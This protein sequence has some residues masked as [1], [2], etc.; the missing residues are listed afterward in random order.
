MR[1]EHEPYEPPSPIENLRFTI[2]VEDASSG[3]IIE[4]LG[5]LAGVDPA[6]LAYDECVR[7]APNKLILLKHNRR[8]LRRSDRPRD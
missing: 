3:R 2:E 8:L 5:R 1:I 6:I 4:I 7:K